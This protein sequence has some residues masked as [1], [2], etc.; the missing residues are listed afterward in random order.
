MIGD[1][2]NPQQVVICESAIDALSYATLPPSKKSTLYLATDGCGSIPLNGLKEV[3]EV[4]LVRETVLV[5]E[6]TNWSI[7][8]ENSADFFAAA[9]SDLR[10]IKKSVVFVA[11]DRSLVALGNAKGFSKARNN[12]LLELQLEATIDPVTGDPVPALKGKLKHP[13]KPAID[14]EISPQ[15]CGSMN[16][17]APTTQPTQPQQDVRATL[18]NIFRTVETSRP[19][20]E[21]LQA[22]EEISTAPGNEESQQ[23]NGFPDSSEGEG[24]FHFEDFQLGKALFLAVKAEME[25]GKGKAAIVQEVLECPGRKYK[26]GCAWFD[27][28]MQKHGKR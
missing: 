5:E 19:Q 4:V 10:K 27:A 24:N 13:G 25:N 21:T 11:H 7:R 16:F 15:M 18:E 6:F 26:Y 3:P 20:P 8:C 2:S 17:T 1:A 9:L 22:D 28:L 23:E 12:G 14:V